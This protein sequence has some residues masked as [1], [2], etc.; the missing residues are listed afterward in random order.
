[1]DWRQRGQAVL[2]YFAGVDHASCDLFELC[3]FAVPAMIGADETS[4]S[5]AERVSF[6]RISEESVDRA[7]CCFRRVGD[8][9]VFAIAGV[10]A[11]RRAAR[12]DDGFGGGHRFQHLVL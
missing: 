3:Q 9:E 4:G 5:V 10:D 11:L 1:M 2:R 7:D 6:F 8:E 12:Q